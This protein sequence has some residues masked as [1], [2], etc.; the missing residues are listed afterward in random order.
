MLRKCWERPKRL[1]ENDIKM[2]SIARSIR[3]VLDS[4]DPKAKIFAARKTARDWRLG[5]LEHRFDVEMPDQPAWPDKPELLHPMKMP[6][7]KKGG[8]D[9]ARI[10]LL[11]SLAHIEF[12]AI[13]LAF[14]MAGRFGADFPP[15]FIDDWLSVGAD[16]AMHF[17]LL[18][19]RLRQLGSHYGALPAHSGLWDAASETRHDV[20]ARLAV[21]P[22]V[23]EARG[24]DITPATVERCKG[25]GDMVTAKILNRIYHDEI[26]HVFA[27]SKWFKNRCAQLSLVPEDHWKALVA[28]HFRGALKPPFNDSARLAG[29]LTR[30]Y[31]NPLV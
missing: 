7:R 26:R 18:E 4:S 27:G 30:D 28:K 12:A 23:L 29:G 22:M 9:R 1:A 2:G 31:Y 15:S 11:H 20:L 24:L 21:V 13:D 5:R 6:K 17:A 3:L 16:E 10:A 25:Q 14:D 19:R 8:S